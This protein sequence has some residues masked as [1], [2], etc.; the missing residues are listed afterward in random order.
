MSRLLLAA[1]AAALAAMAP[2]GPAFAQDGSQAQQTGAP[3][4]T[5]E[6]EAT[7]V[8]VDVVVRDRQGRPLTDLTAGD[9]EVYEDGVRQEIATITLVTPEGPSEI[10]GGTP[11]AV[12]SA[13]GESRRQVGIGP[14]FVA[15]VFDRMSPEARALAHKGAL[16]YLETAQENEF[17]GV[18]LIDHNLMTVQPYTNNRE[19]VKAAIEAASTRPPASFARGE[20]RVTSSARGSLDP[21]TPVTAGAESAGRGTALSTAPDAT[22]GEFAGSV[23]VAEAERIA[24]SMERSYDALMRD[25]QGYATTNG[26]LALVNSLGELP[27][28]KT[29]V[30]FAEGVSIPSAVQARFDSVV[31]T[32]NRANVSV[33]T[34]DAA[35]LR[36]QSDL[37][38]TGSQVGALAAIGI[39]G[40]RDD[41]QAYMKDLELNEDLLREDPA[42]GL[43]MLAERTG[44]FMINNTNDLQRGFR[45]IDADRRFHY[46]LTYTPKN[47][48]FDGEYRRIEVKVPTRGATVRSRSGYVAVRSGGGPLLAHE[49][50][51]LAVLDRTPLPSEIPVSAGAFSFPDPK[52]P[53]QLA[54]LVSTQPAALTFRTDERKKT[55]EADFTILSRIRTAA[56]DVV[57]KM[58]QPYQLNGPA[59][60]V[61]SAKRGEVLFF[62]RPA[63]AP[64][65]Y[66]LEYVVHDTLGDKAGAGTLPFAVHDKPGQPLQVSSLLI[67]ERTERVPEQERDA[68]NP[69]YYEDLLL[70]PNIGTPLSKANDKTLSFALAVYGAGGSP[71]PTATLELQQNGQALGQVPLTVP[72]A[73]AGGRAQIASQLPLDPFPPGVYALQVTVTAGAVKE[74]RSAKFTVVP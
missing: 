35:G 12:S 22:S 29:V 61:E 65:A 33:Y 64:G 62:R 26:L 28:R 47:T 56:G 11:P 63:R 51:V 38:R 4:P 55:F 43:T 20:G 6:A 31:A 15:L 66:T 13:A 68:D 24:F 40:Q 50:P 58:S 16:A 52:N 41:N 2:G 70:Y 60:Q 36:A 18:F 74:V 27:G 46:L 5:F 32:A 9:F 53:G 3:G 54:V 1:L 59:D 45:Q 72:A 7:A 8:M 21:A 71:A 23:S 37:A 25:Q 19:N 57:G 10:M 30:Y 44:G 48:D 73:D 69:L 34:I 17:A 14:A 42:V 49:G 39:S 67:V